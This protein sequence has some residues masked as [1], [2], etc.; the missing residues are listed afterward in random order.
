MRRTHLRPTKSRLLFLQ[1][2]GRGTRPLPGTVDVVVGVGVDGPAES[3]SESV[4]GREEAM[5]LERLKAIQDSEK[6]QMI[7]I[8]AGGYGSDRCWWF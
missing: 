7:L 8:G 3:E 2:L 6:R 1:M 4:D 5:R